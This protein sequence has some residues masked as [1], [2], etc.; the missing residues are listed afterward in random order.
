MN[1][2]FSLSLDDFSP[3]HRAGLNFESIIWCNKL[4]E[5]FSN[6]KIN[7]FVPAAYARLNEKQHRLTDF[8]KWVKRVNAL[9]DNYRICPHGLFHRRSA[10]DFDF[11][12]K[13]ASNNDE[14]QFLSKPQAKIIVNQMLEEF[15]SAGLKYSKVFRPPGWKI[16]SSSA[17]HLTE[18]GFIVAGDSKYYELLKD[19]VTNLKWVSVNW[20]IKP[21]F[22]VKGD[23]VAAGHTSDWTHNFFDKERYDLVC[24][25]LDSAQYE[26]SFLENMM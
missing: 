18:E 9:P 5:R 3:H 2:K 26:F 20:H 4:I 21:D 1:N 6:I 25:V 10:A 7:L 8:P 23:V 12:K 22:D 17:N 13:S 24:K 15:E 14:F 16:S 11:H 19:K